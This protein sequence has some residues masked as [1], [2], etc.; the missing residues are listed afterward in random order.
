MSRQ[1]CFVCFVTVWVAIICLLLTL[2][3]QS[4]K[5]VFVILSML[6][7]NAHHLYCS[8]LLRHSVTISHNIMMNLHSESTCQNLLSLVRSE[9]TKS[10]IISTFDFGSSGSKESDRDWSLLYVLCVVM[11][12]LSTAIIIML[13]NQPASQIVAIITTTIILTYIVS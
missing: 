3:A 12:I 7:K 2:R 5:Q 13:N 6:R 10:K 9:W 11:S 8:I 4:I 1:I